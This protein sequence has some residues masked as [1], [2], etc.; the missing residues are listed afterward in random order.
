MESRLDWYFSSLSDAKDVVEYDI[1]MDCGVAIDLWFKLDF[2]D[3]MEAISN[4]ARSYS[5]EKPQP[6]WKWL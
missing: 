2:M 1:V 3:Q 5:L 4:M 6:Q